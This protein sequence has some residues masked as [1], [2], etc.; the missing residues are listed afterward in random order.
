MPA[1]CILR[2]FQATVQLGLMPL[3]EL[4]HGLSDPRLSVSIGTKTEHPIAR[5]SRSNKTLFGPAAANY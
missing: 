2:C 5:A 3:F 1:K 4:G